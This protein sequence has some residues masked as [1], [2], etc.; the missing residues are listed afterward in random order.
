[1]YSILNFFKMGKF[2]I[3]IAAFLGFSLSATG[4]VVGVSYYDCD[5]YKK[6]I[7]QLDSLRKNNTSIDHSLEAGFSKVSITPGLHYPKDNVAEGKFKNV[8]LGGYS[9]RGTNFATGIHDSIFV[10]VAAIKVADRLMIL[11]GADYLRM[12]Q[13]LT[14]EIVSMLREDGISRDQLMFT[15]THSHSSLDPGK[16]TDRWLA[17][18]FSLAIRSA[19][20]DL[21]PALIGSGNVSAASYVR[22]RVIDEL[23]TKNDDFS[24]IILQQIGGKKAIIGSFSAHA[25]VMS[26]KNLEIS[27]DYPGYWER[28]MEKNFANYAIFCAGAMGSQGP[29]GVDAEGFER[30]RKMGEALGDIVLKSAL[31]TPMKDKVVFSAITMKLNTPEFNMSKELVDGLFAGRQPPAPEGQTLQAFRLNDMVWISTPADFSGEIAL[32]IKNGLYRKGFNANVTGFN[33]GYLGYIVPSKYYFRDHYETKTMGWF[34]PNMGD[35]TTDLIRQIADIVI[36]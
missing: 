33:G 19:I 34:G 18:R 15:A 14:D 24:Y 17:S 26:A 5:Y 12:F 35:Y 6:S 20:K 30:A 10:R 22:N 27:G 29:A 31:T 7:V 28:K 2:V 1:M 4:Q 21:K 13:T 16:I 3:I 25:T 8:G 32:Q 23:G 9:A 36:R 11:V